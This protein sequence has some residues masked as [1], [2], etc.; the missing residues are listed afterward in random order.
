MVKARNKIAILIE[1]SWQSMASAYTIA[2]IS[3]KEFEAFPSLA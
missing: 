2:G 1:Y 3:E